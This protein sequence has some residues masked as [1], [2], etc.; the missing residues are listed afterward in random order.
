MC[1]NLRLKAKA[2]VFCLPQQEVNAM[3]VLDVRKKGNHSLV[4][5][6]SGALEMLEDGELGFVLGHE[7]GHFL[8][9]NHRLNALINRDQRRAEAT[10]LPPMGESLFLRWRK[11]AEISADR[12]GLLACGDFGSAAKGLLKATFGLS[13]RN[14][15]L[16]IDGL[17]A[18]IDEIKGKPEL[19]DANFA[20]HPLLPI[21]LKALELF[22]RSQKAARNGC[23]PGGG[24]LVDD[25]TLA[26]SIDDLMRLT[27]RFPPKPLGQAI[28]RAVALGGALVLSADRDISDYETK[29]LIE[30][31]HRHF[32]DEPEK[33]IRTTGHEIEK[34]LAEAIRQVKEL[35]DHDDKT[36]IVSRLADVALADG[37]LMDEE[38]Q[39]VLEIARRLEVPEKMTYNILIG[40]ANLVGFRVDVKL[41]RVAEDL[42][43]SL[44]IGFGYTQ[45]AL[46]EVSS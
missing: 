10:V 46:A 40:A 9:E 1:R 37:A 4:G 14:L 34:G 24:P 16:D 28:M 17:L 8:F 41:N 6:T 33:E 45:P 5:V 42:R 18:Q 29:I 35:G 19:M 30:I 12:L 21:R 31:L 7:L 26:D 25:D 27:N 11:K 15:N 23:G 44:Q 43:K 32:T 13:D 20:S 2:E 38:G 36:F 3:A 22:S 39:V